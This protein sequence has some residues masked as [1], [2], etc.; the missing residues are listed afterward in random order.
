MPTWEQLLTLGALSQAQILSEHLTKDNLSQPLPGRAR[1]DE[2]WLQIAIDVH[3]CSWLHCLLSAG[4]HCQHVLYSSTG[5]HTPVTSLQHGGCCC[6]FHGTSTAEQ[7]S[8]CVLGCCRQTCAMVV[9][10]FE[11]HSAASL[12]GRQRWGSDTRHLTFLGRSNRDLVSAEPLA[13]WLCVLPSLSVRYY[14]RPVLNGS[15]HPCEKTCEWTAS[16]QQCEAP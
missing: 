10:I 14:M 15:L 4:E 11:V 16:Q 2:G 3:S 13:V 1:D 7:M 9:V 8:E 6:A 12:G 5:S